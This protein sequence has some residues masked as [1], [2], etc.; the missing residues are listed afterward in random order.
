MNQDI[1]TKLTDQIKQDIKDNELNEF[2]KYDALAEG[3]VLRDYLE[4]E[5]GYTIVPSKV[6][7]IES[8]EF[9]KILEN[10]RNKS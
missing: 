4:T 2:G 5:L 8:C 7:V 9:D 1:I 6:Y 10:L 3:Q